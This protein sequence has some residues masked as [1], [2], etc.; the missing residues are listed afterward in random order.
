[1]ETPSDDCSEEFQSILIDGSDLQS[2]F[3]DYDN[4]N[5]DEDFI[6]IFQT[7]SEDDTNERESNSSVSP[8]SSIDILPQ[9]YSIQLPQVAQSPNISPI[10]QQ[11]QRQQFIPCYQSTL[12]SAQKAHRQQAIAR[13]L[14]KRQRRLCS[15]KVPTP[16]KT[17]KVIPKR[18]SS[19]GRFIKSTTGF[20]SITSLQS[21]LSDSD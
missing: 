12:S 14:Y 20:V 2:V 15:K 8:S 7:L 1:M 5:D 16:P 21:N 11:I 6:D 4:D 18:S 17:Q 3:N 9:I 19:N 13:W 10:P